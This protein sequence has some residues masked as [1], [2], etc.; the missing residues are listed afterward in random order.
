M[1][2]NASDKHQDG[3]KGHA[4]STDG[5]GSHFVHDEAFERRLIRKIDR[6]L[7][8]IV[9][10]LYLTSFLDRVNIGNARLYGMEED[11]NMKGNMYQTAVSVLFVTYLAFEVPSNLVLKKLRPSRYI[12]VITTMWGIIATCTGLVQTY[13]QLI[14]LRVVLGIFEAGL[15]PGMAIYLTFFYTRK[16]LAVRIGYL[17]VASALAGACGGLLA[18]AIGNMD[19]IAG[20]RGWRWILIIEG[21]PSFILGIATFF[22]LPDDP[23]SA[24]FLSEDEK[25]YMHARRLQ[26]QGETLDAQKFHWADVRAC[27][28]DWKVWGFAFAQFGA[29]TM[30]YGFSNYLPTVLQQ[31]GQWSA[32]VTQVLTIPC[33]FLG[34]V[35][36]L[37]M[38]RLSDHTQRRGIFCTL[39]GLISI[40]G[41]AILLAPVSSSAHYAGTFLVAMG[42]YVLVGI[43]LAWLPNNLPRYGKRTTATGLQLTIGNA[44]GIMAPFIYATGDKPRYIRG[45]AVS[46]AMVGFATLVYTFFWYWFT[47]Q[48]ARRA[49]G[50]DDHILTN[51]TE[52]EIQELGDEA[53]TFKYIT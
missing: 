25:T 48:N 37:L 18:F 46:L 13:N 2:D 11:L 31:I 10:L 45:H 35:T 50:E 14:A 44:S 21:I 9:M 26:Q 16:E 28:K 52:K 22:L 6:H 36:Y 43:P 47:R 15:F 40:L 29:D 30:L 12:S 3:E 39:F 24:R 34:A 4:S 42:L 20:R 38:A 41:Y 1:A 33:Y 19:G 51:K 7:V 27:L 8:P 23:E 5:E 17:F 49:R 53:P 32:P